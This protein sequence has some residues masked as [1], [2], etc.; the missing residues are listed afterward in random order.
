MKRST[1]TV[2][3]KGKTTK[4]FDK[5]GSILYVFILKLIKEFSFIIEMYIIIL[6]LGYL[7]FFSFSSH[8]RQEY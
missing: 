7:Y 6:L 1:L 2:R 8:I 4:S 5:Y 3:T